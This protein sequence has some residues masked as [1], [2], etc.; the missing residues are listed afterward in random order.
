MSTPRATVTQLF[1]AGLPDEFVVLP[2]ARKAT[3]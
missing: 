3:S 2:Y 1:T